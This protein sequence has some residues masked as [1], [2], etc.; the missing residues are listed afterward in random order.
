MSY[1]FQNLLIKTVIATLML[2]SLPA[3]AW[4]VD[5]NEFLANTVSTTNIDFEGIAAQGRYSYLGSSWNIDGV[6][7]Q[8]SQNANWVVD[9]GFYDR[10]Y[11]WNSGAIL[12]AVRGSTVTAYLPEDVTAVG[13][14]YMGIINGGDGIQ[15]YTVTLSSGESIVV[16][17]NPHPNRA[18]I[19]FTSLD[20]LEI[21]SISF[22][23]AEG[24]LQF[25]NFVFGQALSN[26]SVPVPAPLALFALGLMAVAR[27]LKRK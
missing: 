21:S 6:Q 11:N 22:S 14:D 2:I 1:R 20:G 13:T 25:D 5:R 8:S 12:M 27:Q 23:A 15:D 7:F 17:S 18:F 9:D 24:Y 26:T 10:Y 16:S 4:Y 19:G 3:Q